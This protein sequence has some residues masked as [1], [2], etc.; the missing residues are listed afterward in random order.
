VPNEQDELTP[1]QNPDSV[2]GEPD[3]VTGEID[4]RDAASVQ[5]GRMSGPPRSQT[6]DR[7]P[8]QWQPPENASTPNNRAKKT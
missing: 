7:I 8:K 1:E 2:T 5:L 3:S 4:L 6:G